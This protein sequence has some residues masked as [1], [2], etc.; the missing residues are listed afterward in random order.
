MLCLSGF[1]LHSRWV[2]LMYRSPIWYGFRGG[3]K[4]IHHSLNLTLINLN[5]VK[6]NE[7]K[8]K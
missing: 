4:P 7:M 3:V 6:Q 8:S 2:L 5:F 1:E